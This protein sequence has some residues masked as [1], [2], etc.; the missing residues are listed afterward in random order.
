MYFAVLCVKKVKSMKKNI[1]ILFL[2]VGLICYASAFS[3]Q[4]PECGVY[5]LKSTA[6]PLFTTPYYSEQTY[7]RSKYYGIDI[8]S[9]KEVRQ[10][11]LK[12]AVISRDTSSHRMEIIFSRDTISLEGKKYK[13]QHIKGLP[14]HDNLWQPWVKQKQETP[15]YRF[16]VSGSK[17]ER[18]Y[19]MYSMTVN[20]IK[21]I[22]KKTGK[23]QILTHIGTPT[24][25][26][27]DVVQVQDCNFD[28]YPDF[29]I[30]AHDGGAGPNYGDDF[31]LYHPESG[32]FEYNEQLSNLTQVAVD[33]KMKTITSEFRDGCCHHGG[34]AYTFKNGQ[35]DTL[36]YWNRQFGYF[37]I[38]AEYSAGKKENGKWNDSTFYEVSPV[39]ENT[40]IW[41]VPKVGAAVVKTLE[42]DQ[43]V[44]I[45]KEKP[46]WFYVTN[47]DY[48]KSFK[49]WMKKRDVF[50][51]KTDV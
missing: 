38:F 39:G 41:A 1:K 19:G 33:T 36:S 6:K 11:S 22:N 7:Q 32:K 35:L 9:N 10:Y 43:I 14:F 26:L 45:H 42:A 12:Y 15:K 44:A 28:G 5:Q 50:P 18:G 40:K 49:G 47:T 16:E 25:A 20:A 30:F 51:E 37:G 27:D 21:V 23:V 46:L 3:A 17:K 2:L 48:G 8:I 24:D 13:Q 34:E 29:W 4:L 31:Y